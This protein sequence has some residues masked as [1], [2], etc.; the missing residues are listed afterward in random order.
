M[1]K[2]IFI[3]YQHED[4]DF[5]EILINRVEKA[6]Y[7]AWVDTDK[8]PPGED[9]RSE[10]DQAIKSAFALIVIMTPEAK[11]SEYIT[12]EWA[13]AWGAGVKVIPLVLKHTLLHPRLDALQNLDFSNRISRPWDKLIEVIKTAV[14]I[15]QPSN[16]YVP[17][18]IP[19]YV[20]DA[21]PLLDSGKR[22]ERMSAIEILGQSNHPAAHDALMNALNH[23]LRDVRTHVALL[24]PDEPKAVP[25]LIEALANKE[26]DIRR[27]A[28]EVLGKLKDN[29][30]INPLIELTFNDLDIDVRK[31]AANA[32]RRFDVPEAIE[33]L[34]IYD[35]PFAGLDPLGELE[36]HPF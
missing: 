18:S 29:I 21:V 17:V 4:G 1:E 15:Q 32:L 26:A 22:A 14:T 8:L 23:S 19:L 31:T 33:A 20:K 34:K 35:D 3:S 16:I 6:G 25:A 5:A 28:A 12:Y 9:W 10:I 30:S 2:H 36:D 7:V 27:N 11:A 13:F 24:L